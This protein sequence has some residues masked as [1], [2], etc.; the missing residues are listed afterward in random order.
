[1]R[2]RGSGAA[3]ERWQF[4]FGEA[5]ALWQDDAEAV[6]KRGLSEIGLGDAAQ[7]NLPMRGGRQHNVVR[8]NASEFFEHGAR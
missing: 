6:E 5:Y 2:K 8:L 1:M 4:L 3:C 7:T